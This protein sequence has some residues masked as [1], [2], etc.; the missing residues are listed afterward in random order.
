[1]KYQVIHEWLVEAVDQHGDILDSNCY[2]TLVDAISTTLGCPEGQDYYR[3][4]LVRDEGNNDAG[5]V[6]RQWAYILSDGTLPD[7]YSNGAIIPKKFRVE[8]A[9]FDTAV[10]SKYADRDLVESNS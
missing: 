4:G 3:I 10:V 6:D 2:P 8:F 1:M 5:L 9:K 7:E